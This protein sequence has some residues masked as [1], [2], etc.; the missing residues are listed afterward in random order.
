VG[1]DGKTFNRIHM[2][3]GANAWFAIA[4]ESDAVQ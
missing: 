1:C 4:G 2:I 3:L